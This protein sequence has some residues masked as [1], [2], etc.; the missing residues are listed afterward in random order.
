MYRDG[1]FG[2]KISCP[3]FRGFLNSGSLL[4]EVPLYRTLTKF[5]PDS[6]TVYRFAKHTLTHATYTNV[7]ARICYNY[8]TLKHEI[9][10]FHGQD[11]FHV[12]FYNVYQFMEE[13]YQG[14]FSMNHFMAL[15]TF[16]VQFIDKLSTGDLAILVY[17]LLHP[18]P[19][20]CCQTAHL[21]HYFCYKSPYHR[22]NPLFTISQDYSRMYVIIQ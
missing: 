16:H 6:L 5:A 12:N 10:M 17:Y 20:P 22:K 1:P 8:V 15:L 4:R 19:F 2:T 9:L 11:T 21:S 7:Y 13:T 3:Q 18:F 14:N